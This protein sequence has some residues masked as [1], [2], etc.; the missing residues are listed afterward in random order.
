VE[1]IR[2]ARARVISLGNNS[3]PDEQIVE[4]GDGCNRGYYVHILPTLKPPLQLRLLRRAMALQQPFLQRP[5][6]WVCS[7]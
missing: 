1:C 5:K 6:V 3:E 2:G 4:M 7:L